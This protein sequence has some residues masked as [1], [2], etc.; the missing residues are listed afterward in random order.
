MEDLRDAGQF[1]K[2]ILFH[3]IKS[4]F[5]YESNN[6]KSFHA[7]KATGNSLLE[8]FIGLIYSPCFLFTII[9]DDIVNIDVSGLKENLCSLWVGMH[10]NS[11]LFAL[12]L[13]LF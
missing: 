11:H 2:V 6:L 10:T 4:I 7:S 5:W 8:G 13:Y 12:N 3:H 9:F 1:S